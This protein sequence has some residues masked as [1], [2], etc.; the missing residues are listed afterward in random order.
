MGQLHGKDFSRYN[1][2]PRYVRGSQFSAIIEPMRH[3]ICENGDVARLRR[4]SEQPRAVFGGTGYSRVKKTKKEK[5]SIPTTTRQAGSTGPRWCGYSDSVQTVN[6][7][8]FVFRPCAYSR[9]LMV[10]SLR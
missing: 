3:R 9:R 8:A 5:A 1:I 2:E 7:P 4:I 10:E 6:I